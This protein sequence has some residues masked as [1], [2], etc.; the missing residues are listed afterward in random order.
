MILDG[1]SLDLPRTAITAIVGPSGA[2]KTSMLR[3]LNRLDDPVSGSVS[4]AG[5]IAH[6]ELSGRLASATPR[7]RVPGA[8]DVSG[9]V[10]DNLRAAVEI[11][12]AGALANAPAVG[13]C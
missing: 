9:T 4:F 1:L 11:G 5:Q 10:A 8:S 7:I 2:G 13:T 3:L 12:G 6:H